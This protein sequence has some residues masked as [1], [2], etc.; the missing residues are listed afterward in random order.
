[1]P[2]LGYLEIKKQDNKYTSLQKP[3]LAVL[4]GNDTFLTKHQDRRRFITQ[5]KHMILW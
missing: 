4:A 3:Q 5:S 2:S 1:M